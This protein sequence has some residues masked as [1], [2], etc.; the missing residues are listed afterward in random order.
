M[1]Y[2]ALLWFLQRFLV[3]A[4]VG[5]FCVSY[6]TVF[7]FAVSNV[8]K[9]CLDP[10]RVVFRYTK[11]LPKR[12]SQWLLVHDFPLDQLPPASNSTHRRR[13]T[14]SLC[15]GLDLTGVAVM[16]FSEG[17]SVLEKKGGLCQVCLFFYSAFV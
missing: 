13:E 9:R 11:T 5:I 1:F 17:V 14:V 10:Q 8:S 3:V 7:S 16:C 15:A 2:G 4:T 6:S 12:T